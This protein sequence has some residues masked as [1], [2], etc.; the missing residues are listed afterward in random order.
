M[1]TD[2][3]HEFRGKHKALNKRGEREGHLP[4]PGVCVDGK[5]G[6]GV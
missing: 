1:G 6:I 5:S 4:E 3:H 2:W